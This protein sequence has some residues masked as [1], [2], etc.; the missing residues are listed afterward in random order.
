MLSVSSNGMGDDR[1]EKLNVKNYSGNVVRIATIGDGNCLIHSVLKSFLPDYI[2]TNNEGRRDIAQK[3][4]NEMAKYL[5]YKEGDEMFYE[6]FI[7]GNWLSLAVQQY[8]AK[9]KGYDSHIGF[10]A[11]LSGLQKKFLSS[12]FL[13]DEAFNMLSF[14]TKLTIIVVR[15]YIN[16]ITFVTKTEDFGFTQYIV[17]LGNEAHY[18]LVAEIVDGRTKTIFSFQDQFIQSILK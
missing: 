9:I 11:S 1:K 5:V 3:T 17:I 16:D 2:L 4:R 14:I 15:G 13:G 7:N 8:Y 6:W 18:E 10:D 12:E